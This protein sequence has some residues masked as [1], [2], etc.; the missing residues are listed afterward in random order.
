MKYLPLL[1][2]EGRPT[3]EG[4]FTMAVLSMGG[5]SIFGRA[6]SNLACGQLVI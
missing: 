3:N 4:R 6:V 5:F 1:L 2:G